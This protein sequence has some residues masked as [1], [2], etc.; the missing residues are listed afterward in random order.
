MGEPAEYG[1]FDPNLQQ[2]L[3]WQGFKDEIPTDK[4]V[5]WLRHEY[6]EQAYESKNKSGYKESHEYA[7]RRFN[8]NPWDP[9]R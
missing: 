5:E 9:W 2:A 7:Q 1:R 4:D 6:V 3:A 8:G